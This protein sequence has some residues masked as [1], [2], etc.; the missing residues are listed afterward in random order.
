MSARTHDEP[1]RK[2]PR[3]LFA[4]LKKFNTKFLLVTGLSVIIGAVLNIVVARQGIHSLSQKSA[5]EIESGLN[6]ANREYITNHLADKAQQTNFVLG[7]AYADLQTF[8][9]I[10]QEMVDHKGELQPVLDAAAAL[11]FLHDK[12]EYNAKGDWYQNKSDEQ[13]GVVVWG[14]NGNKGTIDPAVQKAV[15]D[16]ALLD[17]ILP[18]FKRRGSEKL[19]IYLVGPK[20]HPFTRV[21][22]YADMGTSFDATYPGHNEKN[23]YDFFFPNLAESWQQWLKDPAKLKA[24]P[25]TVTVTPPYADAAG[26]GI[27]LTAFNPIWTKDR[28]DFAGAAALD[29][30]LGQLIDSIKDVRLAQ[31][32]FAFLV[33][34][35]GNVLAVNESG[36]TT[37]RL[38]SGASEE[39]KGV[40]I[41]QQYLKNSGSE[42]VASLVLPQD[43][44]IDYHEITIEGEI[45]IIALQRLARVSTWMDARGIVPEQWTMGFVVPKREMYASLVA[46][47][48]AIEQSRTS[49]VTMQILI[50]VGLLAALLLGVYLVSR[51]MTGALVELSTGAT[52]MREGDYSVR[53]DVQSEDEIGQ[54]GVA[55]NEMASEIEA[56]TNNLEDLVSERTRALEKA[57]QEISELNA[58]LAQENIRL[59]AELN[60]ARQLQLMV[61]PAP[62]ELQEIQELDIAGYMAPADEVGGDYYDVLQSDGMVKIGIGDVT[63]HGLESGVLMLMVQTAVRTLLA[64]NERD[65]KKFLSIVN[66]VIYQNI[67]RINS[68]KNMSLTLLDYSDGSLKLTGQ[69][70][71]LIIVRADGSLE[72]FD[73]MAL[74][75]PI[76]LDL[77]IEDFIS[78]AEIKLEAGDVV[79]LFSDGITEA[80]D[81]AA[82]QYGIDRLCDVISKNHQCSSKEI[83]DAI[84]EDVLAHIG[85]NKVYDD[86]TVLVIKRV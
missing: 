8:A 6:T 53:I 13:T 4:G 11:P 34:S 28:K 51:R 67:Q 77:E 54:L 64:T 61:L 12:L 1:Q 5:Y 39:G 74:G 25:S 48:S 85:Y 29:F 17:L 80:E 44:R 69:H 42:A 37:L 50:T 45:Y 32:G 15:D 19:Q 56:Y 60:V 20:S 82:Q 30:T 16:T 59:G 78:D 7:Q 71:D 18:S 14:Y 86:I 41:L 63:G 72:R 68:N 46:A 38:S 79:T 35:D 58:K 47:Q 73:T 2:G 26:G 62:Q 75:M 24:L 65:P 81:T 57:N 43:D 9:D 70:E 31:T 23:W 36:A 27:V 22:D 55:F 52:R 10:V 83:K 3:G 40:G 33:Q 76:G 66:K 21:A 84:I 49:I